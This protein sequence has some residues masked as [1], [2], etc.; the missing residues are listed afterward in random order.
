MNPGESEGPGAVEVTWLPPGRRL[1]SEAAVRRIARAALAH[2]GRPGI[3]LSI[4][5]VDD[6][7]L[8]R[9]HAEHLGDPTPTDVM[10]FDLGPG[11][12]PEGEL[13]VSVDRACA[14]AQRRELQPARELALYVVHGCLHLCGFDDHGEA[15]RRR[16]RRAERAV[17]AALDLTPE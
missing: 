1:L 8:A 11:E 7:T 12:G 9:M 5:F 13:Y 16:M 2:G 15:P 17:L 3:S 10:A 14:E 4:V 6:P